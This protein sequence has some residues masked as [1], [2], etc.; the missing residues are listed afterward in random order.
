[1]TTVQSIVGVFCYGYNDGGAYDGGSFRM[2]LAVDTNETV[3]QNLYIYTKE[4]L[5]RF[6]D[7]VNSGET[8]EGK[9]V[10]LMEDINLNNGKYEV[11]DDGTITFDASAEEWTPIGTET[12]LF[13]GTLEGNNHTIN[14]LYISQ[15]TTENQGLFKRND[16]TIQNL[17]L[18]NGKITSTQSNVGAVVGKNYGTVNNIEN[19]I[20]IENTAARTGGIVGWNFKTIKNCNNKATIEDTSTSGEARIGGIVGQNGG[21]VERCYNKGNIIS[22]GNHTGGIVGF[23]G[24]DNIKGLGLIEKCWNEG[25]ISGNYAT[26][27]IIGCNWKGDIIN[28][29]NT[30]KVTSNTNTHT[31]G[32]VG[33]SASRSNNNNE[34]Y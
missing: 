20:S 1:M 31:G 18:K 26:G 21:T 24:D 15:T 29:Y 22:N 2:C 27:G 6:R 30:T 9:T 25:E 13:K 17:K 7:R 32:I 8:F 4:Q 14:G 10:Y 33:F 11:A 5:E 28:C 23:N 16:G 3:E 19:Y 12:N 34:N